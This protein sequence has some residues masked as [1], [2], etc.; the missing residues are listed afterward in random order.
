V[1]S[2][3]VRPPSFPEVPPDH[4]LPV[5][6]GRTW[7]VLCGDPGHW[8][9][10]AFSPAA[11]SAGGCPEL[12]RHDGPE[13]FLLVAGRLTLLLADGAGGVR[14]V[15]LRPLEPIL[16]TSPHAGFCPDGPH[17]GTALV[18]ERDAFATEYRDPAGWRDP[19]CG[20]P[21]SGP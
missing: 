11:T 17:A 19:R 4:P 10:G 8:R 15:E 13:L 3:T 20:R 14:E 9:A 1:R 6:P 7:Q 18:V 5:E 2:V 16:V 12:E 21:Q